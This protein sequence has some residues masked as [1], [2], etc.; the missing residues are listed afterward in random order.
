MPGIQP[1]RVSNILIKK[2]PPIP[3]FKNTD[4]GGNKM[5]KIIVNIIGFLLVIR[6]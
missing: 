5:F 2:V 3:C 6:N 4:N 1:K